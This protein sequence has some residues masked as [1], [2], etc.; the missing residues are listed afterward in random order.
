M[1]SSRPVSTKPQEPRVHCPLPWLQRGSPGDGGRTRGGAAAAPGALLRQRRRR[2][3]HRRLDHRLLQRHADAGAW[4][5]VWVGV[6]VAG[7]PRAWRGGMRSGCSGSG[8]YGCGRAGCVRTGW[9]RSLTGR[10][11]VATHRTST[12]IAVVQP[13][14]EEY[15]RWYRFPVLA[16][17]F[18]GHQ[19]TVPRCFKVDRTIPLVAV[20]GRSEQRDVVPDPDAARVRSRQVCRAGQFRS[21]SLRTSGLANHAEVDLA[22]SSGTWICTRRHV[23]EVSRSKRLIGHARRAIPASGAVYAARE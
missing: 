22:S 5:C 18:V 10:H 3:R 17:L 2:A 14:P 20:R 6:G 21:L 9:V 12:P 8:C 1:A 15:T 7:R 11:R 19:C 4:V 23:S 16:L 13:F